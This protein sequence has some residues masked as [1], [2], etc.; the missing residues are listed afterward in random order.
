MKKYLISL[1]IC[2][3]GMPCIAQIADINS[4]L[5]PIINE[6]NL[7]WPKN[8]TINVV[9]HGHSVPTGYFARQNVNTLDAYP[10]QTLINLKNKYHTAVINCITTSIGG[11]QSEQ[12]SLRFK[13]QVLCM[14]PDVLFIDYALND[15]A[16]GLE[17]AKNAW[18]KMIELAQE[19]GCKII[20]MT[21]TPDLTEDILNDDTQLAKHA[22]Q[23]RDLAA[24]YKVG[25]VDSYKIFKGITESGIDL[26]GYM[27]QA[28]HINDKGHKIV[29]N[30]INKWF[31]K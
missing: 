3:L 11:E 13:D 12:G 17:R 25:L 4:Y 20:L 10:H 22:Q 30:E 16:I 2:L 7:R 8:R 6:F 27:A 28:N 26:K 9:F 24:K 5:K 23:I 31:I 1:F 18:S 19:Y 29:A 14:R 15:R 21:P